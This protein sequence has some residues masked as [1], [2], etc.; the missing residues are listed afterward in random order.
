MPSGRL[1][2]AYSSVANISI[3]P[4]CR[5]FI[6]VCVLAVYSRSGSLSLDTKGRSDGLLGPVP[7]SGLRQRTGMGS[8]WGIMNMKTFGFSFTFFFYTVEFTELYTIVS[9]K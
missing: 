7:S 2:V 1:Y 5:T 9:Y 4:S 3:F 6:F 8:K